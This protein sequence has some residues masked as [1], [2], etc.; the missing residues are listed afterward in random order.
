MAVDDTSFYNLKGEEVS[1]TVLVQ[2][3]ID[4][5]SQKLELGETKVT[6]FNEGSEIRNLLESFAVDIYTLM[7]EENELTKIAFIETADGEWLDKHGAHPLI[8]LPRNEGNMAHGTVTFSIPDTDIEGVIIPEGTVLQCTENNLE[9]ITDNECVIDVGSTTTTV[10]ATCISVGYDGNCNQNTITV[11]NDDYLD[12]SILSV[13][14]VNAF[15]EGVDYEDDEEYRKRLLAFVR[16]TAFGSKD[17]YIELAESVTGVHDVVLTDATGYTAKILVNG[18]T[19]PT[20]DNVL[21]KVLA[22]FSDTKNISLGHSFTV[23]KPTY[24]SYSF[25]V[26]LNVY[27]EL[28]ESYLT[29]I[30]TDYIH[31]GSQEEGFEFKG[32]DIGEDLKKNDL[33]SIFNRLNKVQSV[34]F[35]QH[36][37]S[38]EISDIT[39]N[40]GHVLKLGTLYITQTVVE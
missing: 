11:I 7:E 35:K 4:Y 21:L 19:K 24:D 23:D 38:S 40:D 26:S 10:S 14:N 6:D 8:N 13:T 36:G 39:V 32:L 34:T 31:G 27:S 9:Y 20:P 3:M 29:N 17:Y 5:Y 25:D 1:R 18:D 22:A 30:I 33:Y 2:Q 28:T 37:Q 12:T 15:Y 16:K